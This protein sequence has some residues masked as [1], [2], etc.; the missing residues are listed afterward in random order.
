MKIKFKFKYIF[1]LIIALAILYFS[2]PLDLEKKLGLR[3]YTIN[4]IDYLSITY[5]PT[6]DINDNNMIMVTDPA[7]I[8]KILEPFH[9][10]Y[11]RNKIY[12]R[13]RYFNGG[14]LIGF[15][16]SYNRGSTVKVL[17]IIE[18]NYL[19]LDNSDLIL[20]GNGLSDEYIDFL[21][22]LKESYQ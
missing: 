11:V 14:I 7:T 18:K 8:E 9:K 19:T 20:Y 16:I 15:I 1:I 13:P 4:E 17:S 5:R 12:P 6:F 22:K 21:L 10:Q 2:Y 3:N